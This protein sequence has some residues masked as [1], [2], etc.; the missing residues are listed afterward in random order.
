MQGKRLADNS[1]KGQSEKPAQRVE[2]THAPRMT[3]KQTR[4]A[5]RKK[6]AYRTALV[7]L[8]VLLVLL[9]GVA[10]WWQTF[11]HK[12]VIPDVNTPDTTPGEVTDIDPPV[13]TSGDRKED[14]FTF[15]VIGR[16]TGGGGNTDTILV[17]A[18]DIPN[19]RLNIM[20]IPRDTM[21]NVSWEVKK[22]NTVYPM[23]GHGD[24]G[25]EALGKEIAQLIG[26]TPDFQVVLEW[27]AVGELVDALGGVQ[28]DVPQN[29]YYVDPT[30]DLVINVKK[31]PQTLDGNLAMQVVRY[32]S[33]P[34]GDLGRV[35]VQQDFLKAVISK[36]LRIE[37]MTRIN[38]L[39]KVFTDNVTTNLTINEIAWFADKAIFG[40]LKMDNVNFYTMPN[41]LA[42]VWSPTVGNYQSYVVPI[43]N[44]LVDLVNEAFNPYLDD[45]EAHE[46]DIMSVNNGRVSS[47]TGKL[48]D[49]NA[50]RSTGPSSSG[51]SSS[52]NNSSKDDESETES[53]SNSGTSG[54]NNPTNPSN[55]TNPT[56]P[57]TTDPQTPEGTDPTTPGTTDP[58]TPG[59][60]EPTTPTPPEIPTPET[61]VT[62]PEVTEPVSVNPVEEPQ[63]PA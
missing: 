12:P 37:N 22:I 31:G 27:K 36:C 11:T 49:A 52:G 25:I 60:E 16:D 24:R 9:I 41:R 55:P 42:S 18:Y 50:N 13:R 3:E 39:A 4:N 8:A 34:T 63:S 56:T 17:G 15:L 32:R 30:Q 57:G 62:T 61:P 7:V 29:M 40:G 6:I 46:L 51:S 33:Y 54:T 19:Q 38:E 53:N 26:F 35:Q 1:A 10:A 43:T 21:V 47:S 20:S 45:L 14:M 48:E 5:R 2:G 23:Y 58:E 44:E 28:F 59:T